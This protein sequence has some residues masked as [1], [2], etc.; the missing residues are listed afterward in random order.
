MRAIVQI[1]SAVPCPAWLALAAE[2]G[3]ETVWFT[4]ELNPTQVKPD[5]VLLQYATQRYDL[6]ALG[7]S[8][9]SC[10]IIGSC[11]DAA[12]ITNLDA[13]FNNLAYLSRLDVEGYDYFELYQNWRSKHRAADYEYKLRLLKQCADHNFPPLAPVQKKY[14]WV[15]IGQ[16]YPDYDC[17]LKHYRNDVIKELW[18]NVPGGLVLGCQD[19]SVILDDP[20]DRPRVS[21]TEVNEHYAASRAIVSVDAHDGAG[22][23]STR[24]IESMHAGHCAFIYDHPGMAYLKQWIKDGVHAFF[25][26]SVIEFQQKLELVRS[27][28][29]LSEKIGAAARELVLQQ[30]WTYTGWLRRSLALL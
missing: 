4:P 18:N 1:N 9:L 22:Y 12:V 20:L 2:R 26:S 11:G 14:E 28:P 15:F 10:P 16:V 13:V 21:P 19:W 30:D 27:S 5:I 23:T 24:T 3:I 25:F 29:E 6:Q 17:R 7:Y 8:G